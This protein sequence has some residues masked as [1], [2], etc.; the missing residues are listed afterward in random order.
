MNK[1]QA[2]NNTRRKITINCEKLNHPNTGLY[3]YCAQLSKALLASEPAHAQLN[4]Y[5]PAS[6][7]S[8]YPAGTK[9]LTH[10]AWHKLYNPHHYTCD[11]WHATNQDTDYFPCSSRVKT[12]LTVHD[13]NYFNDPS[14]ALYKKKKFLANLQRMV[15]AASYVICIS[16]Y[17]LRE[18]KQHVEITSPHSVVYNGCNIDPMIKPAAPGAVRNRPFIFT[19]GTITE[20]K[21]FH[22]LPALL[23]GN[24]YDLVIAGDV[25]RRAYL[26]QIRE[27]AKRLGVTDRVIFTGGIPEEEKYWYYGHCAAF[28]FPSLQEGFGLPVIEAMAFGRPVFLSTETSLPEV[29]ADAAFY[30]EDFEAGHMRQVFREKMDYFET[31]KAMLETKLRDRAAGFSW[32]N[33]AREH[34][35][36]YETVLGNKG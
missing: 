20:K 26:Q 25:H 24:D 21:N 29:G 13:L 5:A 8:I 9:L 6:A 11:L 23:E 36:I 2:A 16:H 19:I 17:T 33:A 27:E 18:L 3:H 14:R 4:I 32:A 7:G 34:W 30:F 31:N 15:H 28:A 35:R 22:V 12:V 1:G 10:H